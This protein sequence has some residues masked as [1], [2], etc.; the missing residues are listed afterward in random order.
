[1]SIQH[2]AG[3]IINVKPALCEK[4]RKQAIN[5]KRKMYLSIGLKQ[6]K[7]AASQCGISSCGNE[8]AKSSAS[9]KKYKWRR[10]RK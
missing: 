2:R 8:M 9:A 10:Q 6:R 3:R 5:N 1:M 4:K 7:K